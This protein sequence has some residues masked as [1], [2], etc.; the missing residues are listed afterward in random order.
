M[1]LTKHLINDP[2]TLVTEALQGLVYLNPYLSLDIKNKVVYQSEVNKSQVSLIC[3]GGSGHEPSHSGFVGEGMLTAAVCGNIF[4]SPNASQVT[5]AI[6]LVDRDAGTLIIVKNY[7]GDV[8]NFGLA[9]EQ[10]AAAHPEKSK[11]VKFL[12]V[13]DDV[14]VGKTQGGLVGRRGLAGTVLVYKIAGAL[15]ARGSDLDSIYDVAEW[16][17]QRLGTIGIGL[18]HCHIPG[19]QASE[20]HLSADAAEIGMGIHNEPGYENVSPIPK[21]KGLISSLLELLTS[22]M[23]P[24]RAFVP[25]GAGS[26]N[27]EVV[28]MVNNL[29]GV[30]ELELSGIAKETVSQLR[31]RKI[32]VQRLLVGTFMTSLNMPGFSLTLLLL[33]RLGE[34]A[35]ISTSDFLALIDDKPNVPGWKWS[36]GLPPPEDISSETKDVP[37]AAATLAHTSAR[38]IPAPDP[39]AFTSAIRRAAT[40]IVQNEPELTRLDSVVGDGDAGLT[41]KSGAEHVLQ[42]LDNGSIN[43]EDVIGSVAQIAK[44]AGD[45]MDG[46]SGALYSI[47]FSALVQGLHE[48]VEDQNSFSLQIWRKALRIALNKLYTYTMARPPSRTLIDPLAALVQALEDGDDIKGA[49]TKASEAADNT[50]NLEAKAGRATYVDKEKVKGTPDPGAEA[51]KLILQA[52]LA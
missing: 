23:D 50:K 27:D 14:S 7:T 44:A 17:S 15:S 35:P 30:S 38:K 26:G 32:N 51:V 24:E 6:E 40:S 52:I 22:T 43:G 48:S 8:L 4:A 34:S 42:A 39:K 20:S 9:K 21:L 45:G 5:R 37:P 31:Q 49:V 28:L 16:A 46:T 18:E 36:S 11:K 29:G 47:F 41:H 19:T 2:S 1:V 12:V 13:G 3:G 25:F 10:Y 33:P